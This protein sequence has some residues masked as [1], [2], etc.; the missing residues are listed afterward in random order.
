M[1]GGAALAPSGL[2]LTRTFRL[3]IAF[4]VFPTAIV[5]ISVVTTTIVA[6]VP[7]AFITVS[8]VT[9]AVVAVAVVA[10]SVASSELGVVASNFAGAF[11]LSFSHMLYWRTE[12][13][14]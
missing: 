3:V 1:L 11:S 10:V 6:V 12:K 4:L 9:V 13:I 5:A 14:I 8:V 2:V 7:V